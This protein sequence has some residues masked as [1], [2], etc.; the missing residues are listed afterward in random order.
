MTLPWHC[1]S[2]LNRSPW[3][4]PIMKVNF[5]GWPSSIR[6][7]IT[8]G[9]KT[10]IFFILSGFWPLNRS[11]ACDTRLSCIRVLSITII[12]TDS[13]FH[14]ILNHWYWKIDIEISCYQDPL[15]NIIENKNVSSRISP[16]QPVGQPM[17]VLLVNSRPKTNPFWT[18]LWAFRIIT[19]I[20]VAITRT[21]YAQV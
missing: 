15:G 5:S 11:I 17:L 9:F 16:Q 8:S 1:S 18:V 2:R 19:T 12:P 10:F 6:F 14:W 20:I 3:K 4:L 7:I 13:V 21:V